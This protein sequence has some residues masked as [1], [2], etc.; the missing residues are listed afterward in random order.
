MPET[1]K[2]KIKAAKTFQNFFPF[3]K[4]D[5]KEILLRVNERQSLDNIDV[6]AAGVAFYGV[7]SL[8]PGITSLISLYAL[9]SD[10][11]EVQRQFASMKAFIPGEAYRIIFQQIRDIISTSSGKLSL[12]FAGGLLLTLWGASRA[13]RAIIMALNVAY[14]AKERRGFIKINIVAIFLTLCGILF[15]IVSLFFIVAIPP[16]FAIFNFLLEYQ[17]VVFVSR[18]ILLAVFTIFGLTLIY[19]YA[20]NINRPKWK[21]S[22]SWGAIT[23][24]ILWLLSSYLFSYYVHNFGNYNE[25]YGS[26]G[27]FIIL[28]M[29]FYITAYL[30]L[31]GAQLNA[32]I[33][34]RFLS[35][36][37]PD[38]NN[39]PS[40]LHKENNHFLSQR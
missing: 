25:L 16:L 29:W 14:H 27:A 39:S 6:V 33:E 37:K 35:D 21:W 22:S 38:I 40:K 18:W 28:L 8:F 36:S 17:G 15:V 26:M 24:T 30:I 32:E 10:P 3:R 9:V 23:V 1:S 5:V 2:V 7:F 20:P 11:V 31:I 19:R 12:G 4:S 13:M 34:N